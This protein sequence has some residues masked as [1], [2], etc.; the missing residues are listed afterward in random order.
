MRFNLLMLASLA[1]STAAA[2][3]SPDALDQEF[4]PVLRLEDFEGG[5]NTTSTTNVTDTDLAGRTNIE[6][7]QAYVTTTYFCVLLGTQAINLVS[8]SIG[9]A[10]KHLSNDNDCGRHSGTSDG[11]KWIYHATGRNCDTTAEL[12]TIESAIRHGLSAFYNDKLCKTVCWRM[13][14]GGT[15]AGYMKLGPEDGFENG[16]ACG[17][18]VSYTECEIGGSLI[19]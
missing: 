7:C 13:T 3:P 19:Y 17:P 14:H 8:S 10:I 2:L 16:K 9:S 1:A 15:W 11:I 4:M 6:I 5:A 12:V 18:G